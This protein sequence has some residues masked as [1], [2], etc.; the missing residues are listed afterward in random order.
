MEKANKAW[1]REDFNGDKSWFLVK[2]ERGQDLAK[3]ALETLKDRKE[4]ESEWFDKTISKCSNNDHF[5]TDIFRTILNVNRHASIWA[6]EEINRI[7]EVLADETRDIH[8]IAQM[9]IVLFE[10]QKIKMD[11]AI[12]NI[13]C[14]EKARENEDK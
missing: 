7:K 5:Y 1:F 2:S 13:L 12:N 9:E 3:A 11:I 8:F 4:K 14:V 6:N 10:L